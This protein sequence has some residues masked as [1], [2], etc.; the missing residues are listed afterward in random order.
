MLKTIEKQYFFNEGKFR[1]IFGLSLWSTRYKNDFTHQHRQSVY[2]PDCRCPRANVVGEVRPKT[3]F[4]LVSIGGY[5]NVNT[6]T[7]NKSLVGNQKCIAPN[8]DHQI[9]PWY[10][11]WLRV[12]HVANYKRTDREPKGWKR[13]WSGFKGTEFVATYMNPLTNCF[14]SSPVLAFA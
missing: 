5:K 1:N 3:D 6:E 13:K 8:H 11:H 14:V 12:V 2:L 10:R 9:L 7:Q 4:K